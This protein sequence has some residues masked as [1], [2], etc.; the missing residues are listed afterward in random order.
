MTPSLGLARVTDRVAAKIVEA[1]AGGEIVAGGYATALI[2]A[3][4][5]R[6]HKLT[7][8]VTAT[9]TEAEQLSE[10]IAAYL[11]DPDAV[12]VWPGWDTHPLERVSPDLEVMGRRHEVR[13]RLA[14]DSRRPSV[15]VSS[16]RA[17]TQILAPEVL[18]GPLE[19]REGSLV[20]RDELLEQLID[21]GYRREHA[22]EHRGECAV[23]GGILDVWPVQ[24]DEP[25]RID[26][27]GDDVERLTVFDVATQRSLHDV[28]LVEIF[29]AREWRPSEHTRQR[30][31]QF[32][33]S[34]S[35]GTDSFLKIA[36]N[37]RFDGMEGW[38][39]WFVEQRRTILS[40]L[41]GDVTVI[42]VEPSRVNERVRDLLEEETELVDAVGKT[43]GV[44]EEI[45]LIHEDFAT[46]LDGRA[47][48]L[49]IVSAP[50]SPNSFVLASSSAPI[51][52]GDPGRLAAHARGWSAHRRGVIAANSAVSAKRIAALLRDEG[53]D[54]SENPE[55]TLDVRLSVVVAPL[56]IGLSLD[57][58]EIT[59]WG[60]SDISGR[61]AVHRA[62][63]SR[64]RNVDGFFDGLV[65]GNYVVHRQHGVA[66][67]SGST[68]RAI[69][70]TTRD[71]LILEFRDGR[72]YWPTDQI[73]ALT[74]YS[75]GD[76]PS[77]SRMGSE[78]WQKTRAKARAAAELVAQD[79]LVLYRERMSAPGFAFHPDTQWQLEMESLFAY[80]ETA[81][82]LRA[83]EEVKADMESSRPMDRLVCADVGFGKTEIALRAI[84]KAV[85][86][87]KQ[88]AV[89]VPTTL[90]ASQHYATLGERFSGFP[91]TVALLSRFV[92]DSEARQTV[93]GLAN[94]SIDVVIGTHR[95]L[96]E[97]VTFKD[98]GLLV[99]DEEQRFGV[100]H[101]EAIKNVLLV[102][103]S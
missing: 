33:S 34:R 80:T 21:F 35:W 24:S 66:R 83:I 30:A 98:L 29:A 6:S 94:G 82:Q 26:L 103:T 1:A 99:V 61:R 57:D 60:E 88:A 93:A 39:P 3:S 2:A 27:F 4:I 14:H 7:V 13:W 10:A 53:L 17:V 95:L 56:S 40:E 96:D 101:K 31:R 75:G 47:V 58:P 18:D 36:E 68:S 79:L 92:E 42:V 54:V 76:A 72:S 69:N 22:V 19:I 48:D 97:R 91:V 28:A 78:Q 73:D 55:A 64:A 59:V 32:A 8:V 67:F 63:R 11:G 52:Q 37:Q 41:R 5:S 84:F 89:L 74:P 46:A 45:P 81:D 51:V 86:D 23:R 44:S 77:L 12:C 85:Q 15:L 16:A 50:M 43:W 49:L 25:V 65:V 87:N 20:A 9:S 100:G 90:L 71:Y 62:P 102:S 70:G 38:M